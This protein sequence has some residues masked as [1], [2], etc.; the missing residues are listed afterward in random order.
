MVAKLIARWVV[1]AV[2]VPLIAALIR[3]LSQVIE[4]RG[5]PTRVSRLL[6]QTAEALRREPLRRAGRADGR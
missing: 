4:E 1:V 2:A 5:G 6:R 3:W